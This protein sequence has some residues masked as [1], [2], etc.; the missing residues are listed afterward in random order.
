MA[1]RSFVIQLQ[2]GVGQAL[3]PDHRKMLP[4]IQYV[5]DADTFSK[6]SLGARQNVIKVVSVNLDDTGSA[7]AATASGTYLLAQSSSGV[8]LMAAASG[9][10]FFSYLTQVGTT[11]S[12]VSIA[13]FAAQGFD[14]GGTEGVGAGV[15]F[16]NSTLS[17]AAS[18]QTVI[19]PD[20]S[21]FTLAYNGTASTISG[22]WCT[23]WQD[24]FNRYISTASGITYTVVADGIGTPYNISAITTLSGVDGNVTTVGTKQ[25]AFAGVALVNIPA[26]N[27]GW[28]QIEGY[29]PNVAV[30]SGTAVGAAVAVSG[31]S[32][33]GYAAVPTN[34]T[35]A[36]SSAGVVTGTALANNVFGTVLTA[37]ASGASTGGQFFAAVEI[38]SRRV[39]KPYVRVLNKN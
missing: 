7:N 3:L 2:P 18:N 23:V 27:F 9:Q 25:G 20:G 28:I 15:S 16:A 13:G 6:I 33:A 39:K 37:P 36:T 35:A 22:G 17:G 10:S 4:G 11:L 38:R 30:A 14:A 12:S 19:G 34:T 1:A 5:V 24:E 32:N 8:N 21:R 31:T 26:G 29:C